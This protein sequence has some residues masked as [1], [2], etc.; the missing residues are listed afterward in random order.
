MTESGKIE[1]NRGGPG[2]VTGAPAVLLRAEGLAVFVAA[3]LAYHAL[4]AAWW[5]F[6]VLFL[7]PDLSFL[8]YLVD[9]RTGAAVYNAVHTYVLPVGLGIL[10]YYATAPLGMALALIWIAHIGIDRALGYGLK[11]RTA[12]GDTHLG[13]R[14]KDISG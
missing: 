11:Y 2:Y 9:R 4:G 14:G 10:A 7:A 5:L 1:V 8:A 3:L 13:Q 6:V 12:F